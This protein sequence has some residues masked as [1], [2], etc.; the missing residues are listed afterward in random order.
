MAAPIYIPTKV[1]R[2]P[3]S[4]HPH[5][6]WLFLAFLI[7]AILTDMGWYVIVVLISF[8]WCLMMWSIVSGPYISSVEKSPDSFKIRLFCFAFFF[9]FWCSVIWVLYIFW[10]LAPYQIY[11]LQIFCPVQ[12]A[13]FS[14]CWWFPLLCRSFF[15]CCSL[16]CLFSF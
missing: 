11:S 4:P 1:Y 5:Q 12:W 7:T 13:A 16:L 10:K 14:S 2:V 6:H 15:V 9:F 8:S 3:F